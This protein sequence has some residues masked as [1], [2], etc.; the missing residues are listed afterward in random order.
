MNEIIARILENP[1]PAFIHKAELIYKEFF[2]DAI[3]G[4]C[5]SNDELLSI[6]G[7][8]IDFD[9][10]IKKIDAQLS[11]KKLKL[12]EY[13]ENPQQRKE[14]ES[15][16]ADLRDSIQLLN[17]Q[18]YKFFQHSAEFIGVTAKQTYICELFNLDG[19]PTKLS[20]EETRAV[21]RS[22]EWSSLYSAG[23]TPRVFTADIIDLINWTKS[24]NN[25]RQHP[26]CPDDH[27]IQNDDMLDGWM[28]YLNK[29]KNGPNV[30]DGRDVFM[31]ATSPQEIRDIQE[32]NS[33]EARFMIRQT[34]KRM[35][36]G[37]LE[38]KDLLEH[39]INF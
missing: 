35:G 7:A 12:Y 23:Y 28:L 6:L 4:G 34:E 37:Q 24:Y 2:N 15:E 36:A 3:F 1:V 19:P 32:M 8:P 9:E 17:D 22:F 20:E 10:E 18:K 5:L 38:E 21:A 16:I 31:K 11:K 26:D 25:I 13:R 30:P 33:P 29:K 39:K 14:V 27:V